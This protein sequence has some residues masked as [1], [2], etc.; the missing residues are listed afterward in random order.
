MRVL[1]GHCFYRT[2][3]PSGE[4]S[5]YR[6]E[7][8]LLASHGVE[9]VLYEK[10][11]DEIR[12]TSPS[13]KVQNAINC[14]WSRDSYRE[15][16]ALIERTQ[17]DIAHFHNTFPQMSPSVYAAC[18]DAG[19]PVVQ[20]LHNYRFVCPGG[21]L[22][23][24]R[25]PCEKCLGTTLLPALQHRCYR[26][27][28]LAT[29]ALAGNIWLAQRNNS[30]AQV[31][32]FIALTD[33]ARQKFIVGGLPASRIVVKPN[34]SAV[35]PAP[36]KKENYAV[37]VGR[38]S[39]EKGVRTLVDAWANLPDIPLRVVGDG[40][41]RAQLEASALASGAPVQFFGQ[42][43]REQTQ[44]LIARARLQI[45]P[46]ECYEGFP[47]AV[48][49]AFAARTPVLASRIG[50][51]QE[52]IRHGD[53]G[54]H[55]TAGDAVDL[56]NL[57]TQAWKDAAL[58]GDLAGRA[59]IEFEERYTPTRNFAQLMDVYDAARKEHRREQSARIA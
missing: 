4:D 6:N 9:L 33:F 20:T 49:E 10:Q 16:R 30:F 24:D 11:N 54:L 41:L 29:S 50:S 7:K 44:G 39:D 31:H 22:Q 36:E 19:I 28:L 2:S 45:V 18:A 43:D 15:L 57:V 59:T 23:R 47:M 25:K 14:V 53:N 3:A 32:R 26:D 52:I 35:P 48:L 34:F 13:D 42:C 55:F 1:L 17:P 21:L 8:S 5:V 38:L 12:D 51:L 56:R 27:S 58:L 37:Y 46:S 40:P